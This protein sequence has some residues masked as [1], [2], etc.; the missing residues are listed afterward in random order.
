MAPPQKQ[1]PRPPHDLIASEII[2]LGLNLGMNFSGP[3]SDLHEKIMEVLARQ[4]Q[5]WK[6][7][8]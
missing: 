2:E 6:S 1:N 8:L 7:N 4:E 5:D 3:L